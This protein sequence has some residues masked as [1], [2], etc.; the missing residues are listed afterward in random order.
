MNKILINLL[1]IINTDYFSGLNKNMQTPTT[2][3]K[4]ENYVFNF[5]DF[6]GNGNFSKCYKGKN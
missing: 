3:K 5:N 2:G 1:L 4:I 6:I